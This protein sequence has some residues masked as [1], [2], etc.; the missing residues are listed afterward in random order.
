MNNKK[1]NYR[2]E[3]FVEKNRVTN[4][5]PRTIHL[6]VPQEGQG[7]PISPVGPPTDRVCTRRATLNPVYCCRR[8]KK[9]VVRHTFSLVLQYLLLWIQWTPPSVITRDYYFY[10]SSSNRIHFQRTKPPRTEENIIK[11]R[12]GRLLFLFSPLSF[13]V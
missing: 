9:F 2:P 5:E 10:A 7:D 1:K 4:A 3:I 6:R 13:F 8:L 12:A 11:Y